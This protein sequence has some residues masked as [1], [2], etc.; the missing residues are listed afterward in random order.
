MLSKI[1][2][3]IISLGVVC[4]IDISLF[5]IHVDFF[6]GDVVIK[7][8]GKRI[9][10]NIKDI[11]NSGDIIITGKRSSIVIKYKDQSKITINSNSKVKVG[12][13]KIKGSDNISIFSGS[14]SGKYTK[15]RKGSKKIYSPTTVAAI[16]GTEFT[17][18]VSRS[19]KTNV[20]LSEGKLDINNPFGKKRMNSGENASINIAD[21]PRVKKGE[22][23]VE[24]ISEKEN[25]KFN[26]N[27]NN[28][29]RR[30]VKYMRKFKQR[31]SRSNRNIKGYNRQIKKSKS[32][33]DFERNISKIGRAEENIED[34]L[35]LNAAANES[36]NSI[37]EGYSNTRSKIY[38][39]FLRVKRESNKVREQQEK[40]H[41]NIMA[42]KKSY[43]EAYEKIMGKFNK[44][45]DD[46]S[47]NDKFDN[48]KPE[49]KKY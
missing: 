40:N 24:S 10:V 8:S 47:G 39:N 35:M 41:Q 20:N 19:G 36:I 22:I 1:K 18:G 44:D 23:Q 46:I 27:P 48:I 43:L 34:D 26:K 32:K 7:R 28:A 25:K 45:R 15:L 14:L 29:A 30:Y 13:L 42:V 9:D 12:D 33:A 21:K 5:A 31:S 6:R 37:L 16:R 38:Q 17:I 4:F 2:I 11:L 49:I 3:F